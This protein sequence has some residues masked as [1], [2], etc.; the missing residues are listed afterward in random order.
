M[1]IFSKL[2]KALFSKRYL[3][4]TNIAAGIA[5]ITLGDSIQQYIE[6]SFFQE[7][8]PEIKSVARPEF[9][10]DLHRLSTPTKTNTLKVSFVF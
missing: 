8:R 7:S 5:S 9:H 10:L 3:V 1:S 6:Y 2:T 4:V